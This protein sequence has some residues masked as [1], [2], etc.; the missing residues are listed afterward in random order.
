MLMIA[1]LCKDLNSGTLVNMHMGQC[2]DHIPRVFA[3]SLFSYYTKESKI[4]HR[5]DQW[6]C[7][8]S[9]AMIITF[10]FIPG[11]EPSN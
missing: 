10:I 7:C 11:K 6:I 3:F 5:V 8:K 4:M 9:L 1:P 2:H